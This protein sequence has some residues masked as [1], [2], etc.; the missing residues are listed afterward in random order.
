M[1]SASG[2]SRTRPGK[3]RNRKSLALFLVASAAGILIW[4]IL[5]G[6]DAGSGRGPVADIRLKKPAPAPTAKGAAKDTAKD[7]PKGRSESPGQT[8]ALPSVPGTPSFR[9]PPVAASPSLP[10]APDPALVEPGPHGNLPAIGRDGRAPWKVYAAPFDKS[11]KRPRIALIVA[12]LGLDKAA[13]EAAITGLPGAVT[14]AFSPHADGLADW[15]ARARKAGHE[16][17]LDM[18]MEPADFPQVDP[19]PRA[20]L[21]SLPPEKNI[22][23]LRWALARGSGYVGIMGT[24][25]SKFLSST[26]GMR[27]VLA[28]LRGRGLMFLDNQSAARSTV[29]TLAGS[30]LV[31]ASGTAV[32]DQPASRRS[33]DERLDDLERTAKEK[34]GAVGFASPLPVTL[35]RIAHWVGS[36]RKRGLLLAPVSALAREGNVK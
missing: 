27:P 19:G 21:T 36:A 9:L 32:V 22:D 24:M 3:P 33:I 7:T 1:A 15:I 16:V 18:P 31:W 6:P 20:L 10:P 11:D 14:L 5:T 23:R 29:R 25:G 17:L 2:R 26:E 4:A 34:G 12:G 13:T 35:Q 8:A 28:E 30:G